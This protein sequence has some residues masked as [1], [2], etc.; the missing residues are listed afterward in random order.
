MLAQE[1]QAEII[2]YV[3]THG[4]ASTTELMD[5]LKA[6][7]ATIR[8]DL[9]KLSQT[10]KVT[11]V[12]GGVVAQDQSLVSSDQNLGE[13]KIQNVQAKRAI[14]AYAARLIKPGDFVFIDAGTTTEEL[15][16]LVEE[17]GAHYVTNSLPHAQR[18]IAR[19]F[20]TFMPAGEIKPATLALVGEETI[21]SLSRYHFTIGFWGTNG[22][23]TENGLT[24]PEFAEAAVKELT[25]RQTKHPYALCDRTKFSKV[26]LVTFAAFDDVTVICDGTPGGTY[27]KKSNVTVVRV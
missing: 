7:S 23:G 20:R 27:D 21:R 2:R 3:T 25:I 1:R 5:A 11:R 24:T 15:V 4:A 17:H 14:A 8:R 19:G 10:G 6:S 18:L 13:R 16:D 9:D 22:I 12:H 26:S